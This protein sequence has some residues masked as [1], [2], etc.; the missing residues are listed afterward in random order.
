MEVGGLYK[1]MK[2]KLI[3][4]AAFG[5]LATGMIFAQ[6]GSPDPAQTQQ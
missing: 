5:A 6:N 2:N 3:R 1:P 4:M